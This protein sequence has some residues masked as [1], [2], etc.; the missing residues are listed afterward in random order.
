[1]PGVYRA[2]MGVEYECLSESLQ[3]LHDEP[4]VAEGF[5]EVTGKPYSRMLGLPAPGLYR[6]HVEVT[7][8]AEEE[9]WTRRFTRFANGGRST[10]KKQTRQI[11]RDG[12]LEERVGPMRFMFR[13]TCRD[14]FLAFEQIGCRIG[15]I[16]VPFG[17][18]IW[19][20]ELDSDDRFSP[21]VSFWLPILGHVCTYAGSIEFRWKSPSGSS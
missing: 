10:W 17:M 12:Y 8:N 20:I 19:A 2:V 21:L 15:R 18:Q 13:L 14:G 3:R 1:M 7:G 5:L 9:V 11:A 4:F 6:V 16:P